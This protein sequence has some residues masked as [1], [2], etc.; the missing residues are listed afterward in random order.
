M[1][2][3]QDCIHWR[4]LGVSAFVGLAFLLSNGQPAGA[5]VRGECVNCHTMHNSQDGNSMAYDGGAAPTEYLTRGDC[6]AC[7]AQNTAQK[8]ITLGAS[9]IPQVSH[10]D[11]SGDLAGGNFAFVNG[12]LSSD[13]NMGH[14][15]V[16]FGNPD[17]T[18]GILVPGA[19]PQHASGYN[20][21]GL[22]TCSGANGCH[23][24]RH[25]YQSSG[26][27]SLAG[28][29]HND[30]EGVCEPTLANATPAN[31]YR[32]LV[33]VK[34]YENQTAG[35]KW[36][37]VDSASHNE[38]YGN[39]TPEQL[40]CDSGGIS[41]HATPDGPVRPPSQTISGF[42]GT[43]HGNFH[44]IALGTPGDSLYADGIGVDAASPFIRHPNDVV[45]PIDPLA[46]YSKYNEDNGG[47]YNVMAPVARTTGVPTSPQSAITP[48][49]DAVMCLSC[50]YAH[51]SNFPN[52]L[53]WDY[54]GMIAHNSG[55]ATGSGCFICHT[56]KD[57]F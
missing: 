50:H 39:T 7:H 29:H 4:L 57:D 18:F 40:G 35:G 13:D 21:N 24:V 15:V 30:V 28:S 23:G 36:Q 41:C 44:T 46:E 56:T 47:L 51:G 12:F 53:R 14:N 25:P 17:N 43:C 26:M 42:C 38:Y 16:D 3:A 34:G 33:G 54:D 8:I 6:V 9:Q 20:I 32:F 49:E 22:L 2:S 45:L 55:A 10:N 5:R 48:G 27:Q 31:S 11:S 52:M 37:N 19:I 1:K